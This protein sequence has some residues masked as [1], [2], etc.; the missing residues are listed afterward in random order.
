MDYVKAALEIQNELISIQHYLHENAEIGFELHNT[1]KYVM[2][3]L[4]EYG[5]EPKIIGNN[6]V[7][8]TVGTPGTTILLRADMDALPITEETNL[9]YAAKNGCMHACGHDFHTTVLLGAAKLL[10]E[11]EGLLSGTVKLFFQPAE[12]TVTGC[13]NALDAGLMENPKVN[14]AISLHT[15]SGKKGQTDIMVNRSTSYA[16]CDHYKIIIKGRGSHGAQP[17]KSIDPIVTGCHMVL[18]LQNITSREI[19]TQSPVI[20]TICKIAGG[21][22]V[23]IIPESV[24]LLG[25]LRTL[26]EEDRQTAKKRILE[27]ADLTARTFGAK[28]TVEWLA[29]VPVLVNDKKMAKK[30][31]Q[32]LKETSA[33]KAEETTKVT[34]GSEDFALISERVPAVYFHLNCVGDELGNHPNSHGP[35]II[36]DEGQLYKGAAAMAKIAVSW[37]K[38][39]AEVKA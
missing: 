27:I 9:P 17:H 39:N 25:T 33:L 3:K 16:S 10:K 18:A 36:Y 31:L 24:E 5:Y 8:A 37:L 38:D 30:V 19:N 15:A 35:F 2:A 7:I 6:S 11:N 1:V 22:A 28:A 29:S 4:T 21:S 32:Y 20:Q 23:N 26:N 12:E 14:A 13:Q 34:M